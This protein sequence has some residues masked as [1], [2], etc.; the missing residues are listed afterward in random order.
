MNGN[1]GEDDVF[2]SI[3]AGATWKPVFGGHGA[4]GGTGTFDNALAP[5]VTRTPIHW[6]FDIEIDPASPVRHV[7]NIGALNLP[8]GVH[9]LH[10]EGRFLDHA[11]R[12][13]ERILQLVIGRRPQTVLLDQVNDLGEADGRQNDIVTGRGSVIHELPSRGG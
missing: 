9:D 3:D 6:M 1:G 12:V 7:R 4:A 8:H 11:V 2:R 13:G 5:Y 10:C